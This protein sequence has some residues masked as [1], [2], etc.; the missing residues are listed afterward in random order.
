[1]LYITHTY[2]WSYYSEGTA[3][4]VL[5]CLIAVTLANSGKY[6]DCKG[7]P[8]LLVVKCNISEIRVKKVFRLITLTTIDRCVRN[9]QMKW[10]WSMLRQGSKKA[11]PSW[12]MLTLI[13]FLDGLRIKGLYY[14]MPSFRGRFVSKTQ[15]KSFWIFNMDDCDTDKVDMVY[16]HAST[17]SRAQPSL[18]YSDWRTYS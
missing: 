6:K 15:W 13:C 16:V 8:W 3:S 5:F 11:L 17:A 18:P 10:F 2:D 12:V 1:M 4:I 9:S 14:S 7:L